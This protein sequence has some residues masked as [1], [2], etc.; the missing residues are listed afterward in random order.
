MNDSIAWPDFVRFVRQLS[1]DLRNQLNAAELQ[2]ALLSELTI[3]PE[4]RQEVKRLR[5]IVAQTGV[6]LQQLSTSV[7]EPRPTRLPYLSTHLIEDLRQ[8][9]A[10]EHPA[11]SIQWPTDVP[12]VELDIDP[13]LI[14]A[15]IEQI[16]ANA[17]R[18]NP[19][20]A[21]TVEARQRGSEFELTI[22]EPARAGLEP[23][24]LACPL[25][26]IAH[27]HY[28]LGRKRVREIMAAHGGSLQTE[29]TDGRLCNSFVLPCSPSKA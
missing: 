4:L 18:H 27:G 14:E 10:K 7:A 19:Q 29:I 28:G 23:E 17:I 11:Q 26:N 9:L 21:V 24:K 25:Q 16:F 22:C 5:E 2:A 6:L 13:N 12:D 15:A 20:A 1:H 3:D 8:K